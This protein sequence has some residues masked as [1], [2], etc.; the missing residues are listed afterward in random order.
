MLLIFPILNPNFPSTLWYSSMAM[1]KHPFIGDVP[2]ETSGCSIATFDY[3]RL[4]LH[5][6]PIFVS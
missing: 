4:Y 1:E 5:D 2:T 3:W 6:I